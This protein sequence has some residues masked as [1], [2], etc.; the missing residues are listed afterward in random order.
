[1]K[2]IHFPLAPFAGFK[3][4]VITHHQAVRLLAG[5]SV[6]FPVVEVTG[7]FGKTAAAMCAISLLKENLSV[8]SLTSKGICFHSPDG[9]KT[10]LEGVSAAP[11]NVIRAIRLSPSKP[12]IAIFE[13]SLGGTGLADLG[14]IKNVYDDY[15][16]A[17]GTSSALKAK[18]SMVSDRKDGSTILINADDPKLENLPGVQRF[19]PSGK[20]C[21]IRADCAKVSK[22]GIEFEAIF[23][24]FKAKGGDFSGVVGV[25]TSPGPVGRQH[26]ENL[27]LGVAIASYFR[28]IE[29][30]FLIGADA[31]DKKMVLISAE[32]PVVV[33]ASASIG[34]KSIEASIRDYSEIFPPLLLEVGGKLKTTCGSVDLE[35]AAQAILTSAFKEIALFGEFGEALAPML[36]GKKTVRR[37]VYEGPRLVLERG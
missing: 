28:P 1:V 22:N 25:K 21:E 27:L 30:S 19:S 35:S 29:G 12:D 31:F 14:I 10:L 24:G 3:E 20:K 36:V 16:I 17:K 26:V 8:L 13:L 7:S 15:P 9:S 33:N 11:A 34:S 4:R 37:P 18:L 32:P 23:E 5:N 6:G 2:P